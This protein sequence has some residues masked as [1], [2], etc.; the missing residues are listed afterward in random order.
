MNGRRPVRRPSRRPRRRKNQ[1][2]E[3]VILGALAATVVLSLAASVLRWLAAHPWTVAAALLAAA[4]GARA[5]RRR[6]AARW[7]QVRAS[8]LRYALGQL[9][10]LHHR[11]SSSRCGT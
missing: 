9:D 10:G 7:D 2:L 8:G 6:E 5:W 4:A 1:R 3:Q 11:G